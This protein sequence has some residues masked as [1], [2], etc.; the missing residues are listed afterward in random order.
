[1]IY[2]GTQFQVKISI[3]WFQ[4]GILAFKYVFGTDLNFIFPYGIVK[5]HKI[6]EVMI[7][8]E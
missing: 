5:R 4:N 6:D 8:L 3:L 2:G 1:M 7:K